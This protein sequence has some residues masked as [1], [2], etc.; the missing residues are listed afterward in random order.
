M[1][2]V[3]PTTQHEEY[4]LLDNLVHH[5]QRGLQVA[6]AMATGL[7]Y[8]GTDVHTEH[9]EVLQ[10]TM[11][12]QGRAGATNH[13]AC[14]QHTLPALFSAPY[15]NK[16]AGQANDPHTTSSVSKS[17]RS[18]RSNMWTTRP[19]WLSIPVQPTLHSAPTT[20]LWAQV[21]T[22]NMGCK[23]HDISVSVRHLQVRHKQLNN[24]RSM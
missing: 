22:H 1:G 13:T 17:G 24:S 10:Q 12:G 3:T 7:C 8:T 18:T 2:G 14:S 19:T 15:T 11:R 5:F 6:V 20:H 4:L 21:N 16:T 9:V 23:Q